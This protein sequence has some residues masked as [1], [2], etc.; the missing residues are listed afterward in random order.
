[1]IEEFS[2]R[3]FVAAAAQRC[4]QRRLEAA[5]GSNAEWSKL[6]FG[7]L[8]KRLVMHPRCLE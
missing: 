5:N 7:S 8:F 2:E 1:M 6:F 3:I 4:R